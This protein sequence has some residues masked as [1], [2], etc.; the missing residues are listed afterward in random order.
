MRHAISGRTR[1]NMAEFEVETGIG[2]TGTAYTIMGMKIAMLHL[3]GEEAARLFASH[4]K[5]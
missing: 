3:C 5:G 1:W 2:R 4:L